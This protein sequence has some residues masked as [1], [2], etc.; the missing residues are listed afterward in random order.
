MSLRQDTNTPN[1]NTENRYTA[2][3]AAPKTTHSIV[4]RNK[5][6]TVS[7]LASAK[8]IIAYLL[9]I[10]SVSTASYYYTYS[11]WQQQPQPSPMSL[12]ST[13]GK[14][15]ALVV[16]TGLA[17]LTATYELLFKHHRSVVLFEKTDKLGG[18][19]I[20]ASSGINGA[21]TP[22]QRKVL[23][24]NFQNANKQ[25]KFDSNEVVFDSPELFVN[26]TVK[27]AT[28]GILVSPDKA[29]LSQ[30]NQIPSVQNNF[31]QPKMVSKLASNSQGAIDWLTNDIGLSLNKVS[32]LGGHSIAR[33]HR[34]EKLPPGFEII[35]AISK[36]LQTYIDTA[37]NGQEDGPTLTILKNTK[38][39]K[40][41]KENDKVVGLSYK[42]V[43]EGA[44]VDASSNS[45]NNAQEIYGP[46]ILATGG[47]AADFTSSSSKL[48]LLAKY[49]PDLLNL[50]S[51]NGQQTTGDGHKLAIAAG[52]HLRNMEQVQIHPTGFVNLNDP[53]NKWK[54]LA[55]EALRGTGGV[56][57][58]IDDGKRFVNE[59]LG[60]DKVTT[61]IFGN[62]KDEPR[63]DDVKP[64]N[65]GK[66]GSPLSTVENS[67]YALLVLGEASYK[68]MKMNIDFYIKQ[69]LL[70]KQTLAE[71][72]ETVLKFK[73][74]I[75][76]IKY[77]DSTNSIAA[78]LYDQLKLVN[79]YVEGAAQDPY[80][81]TVW[82]KEPFLLNKENKAQSVVYWGI[83]TPVIHF[84]MGGVEIDENA[85]VIAENVDDSIEVEVNGGGEN[86]RYVENLYAAGEVTWGV[87]G[88]NRLGGSSLLECV[89]FGKI[90]AESLNA[91]WR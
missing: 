75:N 2:D 52:A 24:E 9:L 10:I 23:L 62:T 42:S 11:L 57:V 27:S 36:K 85:R 58:G 17:G 59:L 53:K 34:G 87:H 83:T 30:Y 77:D 4:H 72:S 80:G 90:A 79:S 45:D 29:Y 19:S 89:V 65:N 22:Q 6:I 74:S 44:D 69:G 28:E 43:G 47:F 88:R 1:L 33:T 35:S 50:P 31:Y 15:A 3:S 18:N 51:T 61:A 78:N 86:R 54:F 14:P 67:K 12:S 21:N 20:K 73:E 39:L 8:R 91:Y 16:G 70:R 46:V 76:G 56:L 84:T 63:V 64:A 48:S 38:V 41:L 5:L 71:L 82:A 32:Q 55:G 49:R 40:L 81:R 7:T 13:A 37:A 60:R 26:D 68:E 66:A 25:G